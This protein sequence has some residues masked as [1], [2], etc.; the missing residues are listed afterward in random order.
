[1]A[2]DAVGDVIFQMT[3]AIRIGIILGSF[4]QRTFL[5]GTLGG[6]WLS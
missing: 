2:A 6:G 4:E 3:A 5:E 1:L